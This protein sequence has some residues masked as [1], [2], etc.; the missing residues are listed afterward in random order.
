MR[1]KAG[2]SLTR[3]ELKRGAEGL[4]EVQLLARE[5]LHAYNREANRAKLTKKFND[6]WAAILQIND[7]GVE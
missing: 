5:F 4:Q 3:E 7:A 1:V 2:K 6:V